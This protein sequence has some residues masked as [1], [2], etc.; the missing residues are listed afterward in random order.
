MQAAAA[1][2]KPDPVLIANPALGV[3][4]VRSELRRGRREIGLADHAV[5]GSL[6]HKLV[7]LVLIQ[8][9][10]VPAQIA[11]RL[12]HPEGVI[13]RQGVG[14]AEKALQI[15]AAVTLQQFLDMLAVLGGLP[16]R[17]EIAELAISDRPQVCQPFEFRELRLIKRVALA[18]KAEHGQIPVHQHIFSCHASTSLHSIVAYFCPLYN[19]Y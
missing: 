19:V 17:E 2:I 6:A 9:N 3:I 15:I 14:N 11:V 13:Q 5:K 7:K 10:A 16:P 8:G 4:A 1:F 12:F 18:G